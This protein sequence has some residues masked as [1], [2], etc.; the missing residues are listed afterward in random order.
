MNTFRAAQIT[1]TIYRP[2]MKKVIETIHAMGISEY[3]IQ[4]SRAVVLCRKSGFLGIGAGVGL[5]EEPA[6]RIFFYVPLA[7]RDAVLLA[8][9]SACEL[10]IPGRGSI[11]GEEIEI[12]HGSFWK[13]STLSP[14]PSPSLTLPGNLAAITCAVQRGRGNTIAK[15]ILNLGVPMP[16]VTA[17]IGTGLRDKLGLIRIAIPPEKEVVH[18]AVASH[19]VNEILCA[20]AEA[21]RIDRLGAGFL[22]A[23]PLTGGILNNMVIRGQR[24]SASIEQ[25][26]AAV[27]ELKGSTDWRRRTFGTHRVE[28]PY[29]TIRGLTNLILLCNEGRAGDLIETAMAAGA[30]GATIHKLRYLRLDGD[31]TSISPAREM[32]ELVVSPT[33]VETIV[34]ALFA[35]GIFQPD[36]AGIL[37]FKPVLLACTHKS[38]QR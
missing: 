2:V 6:D 7:D 13:E 17:G 27:D 29:H 4:S 22:Y 32:S 14:P 8:V 19:E 34:E 28:R 36:V 31:T 5:E 3:H 1:C 11:Y 33:V 9:A 20:L 12:L 18:A 26:I 30:S 15:T 23:S 37:A 25:L 10:D 24:H 16:V 38:I 35:E 21:G